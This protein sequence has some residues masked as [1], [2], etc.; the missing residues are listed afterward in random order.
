MGGR[1]RMIWIVVNNY[2]HD[3]ATG[4]LLTAVFTLYLARRLWC[5]CILTF[6][7]YR[8]FFRYLSRVF[9]IAAMVVILA[10]IPRALYFR[11]V[12]LIPMIKKDMVLLL[13]VKYGLL[14]LAV[15]GSIVMWYRLSRDF[16]VAVENRWLNIKM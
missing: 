4:L 7:Q 13:W 8:I 10:G 15:I 14:L 12:E 5:D 9:F 3:L 11:D 2:L 6:T 16:Y 1:N